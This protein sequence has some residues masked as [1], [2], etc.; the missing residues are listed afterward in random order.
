MAGPVPE[1]H[2]ID[3]NVTVQIRTGELAPYAPPTTVLQVVSSLRDRGLTTPVSADVLLRAGIA[4]S[5]VPRTLRSLIG[6]ELIDEDG[7][8]TP[9]M[10]ALRRAPSSDFEA[11]LEEHVRAVY[12]EVFQFTDPAK[13]DPKRIAD[14]F[15][16]YE[17]LGQRARMVTL[18]LGLCEAA[19]IIPPNMVRKSATAAPGA[20]PRKPS[21]A[22]RAEG[23]PKS[24]RQVPP[25]APAG[26]P[27]ALAGFLAS[28]PTNGAGWTRVER[29]RWLALF[30][31]VLDYAIPIREPVSPELEEP[32]DTD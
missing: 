28:I 22:S 24:E 21:A 31:D 3:Y 4:D 17:P 8:L 2:G 20:S 27:P 12:A 1:L 13:D 5:L 15:R 29:D 32:D 16:V 18:F 9:A 11:R 23:R 30:G 25:S 14:A 7:R 10:E 26:L 6:L 19:G